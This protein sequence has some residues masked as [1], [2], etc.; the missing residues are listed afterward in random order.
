MVDVRF[1]DLLFGEG[2]ENLKTR[3]SLL[4]EGLL[5]SLFVLVLLNF[6]VVFGNLVVLVAFLVDFWLFIGSSIRKTNGL[7]LSFLS[8]LGILNVNFLVLRALLTSWSKTEQTCSPE[9]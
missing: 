3:N 8:N 1:D 9:P 4:F 5:F 7:Y 2:P 6:D